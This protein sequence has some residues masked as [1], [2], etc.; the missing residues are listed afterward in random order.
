METT[1]YET[2]E[3]L[4]D[5]YEEEEQEET[6]S[7]EPEAPVDG[8]AFGPDNH[9]TG[10]L[11]SMGLYLRETH[12]HRLL[13]KNDEQRYSR[14]M[15]KAAA[16]LET[17]ETPDAG[18]EDA[19]FNNR[20]RMIEGNLR[21][22]ISIAKQYRHLGLPLG[23]LIQEGNIG[24]MQAVRKFEPERNLK[25][26]TYATWWIRQAIWRALSQKSRTI[27]VPINKLDLHRKAAKVYT[28][29]EQRYQNDP[30]RHGNRRNPTTEEVAE[31]IGV[32]PEKLH[33]TLRSVPQIDSLD[34]PV[35][36]DGTLRVALTPDPKQL[37]PIEDVVEA[38]QQ[39]HV[40][41][42]IA[43]L[44][45]RLQHVLRRRFGMIG[46]TEA[47]LEEIGRELH[48]TR[49]RVRQL[50]NEALGM[51]R[52]DLGHLKGDLDIQPATHH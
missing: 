40:R 46:G 37:N 51:L 49:E 7:E 3:F 2:I 33:D 15:R 26:S 27:K 50:E 14:A 28:E 4:D 39:R 31:E 36:P 8:I 22:V 35:V 41:E 25:F 44:P 24:L 42:A 47:N 32:E 16:D 10:D 9:Q 18:T 20:R 52:R 30:S 1:E 13:T 38:E 34:A 5:A 19:F 17:S 12:R 48:I 21:L 23:D 11:D 45:E 6:E 43:Q 29:L